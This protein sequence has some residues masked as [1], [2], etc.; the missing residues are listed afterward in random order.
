MIS[1]YN[2]L[3]RKL[4]EFKP[5]N[6]PNVGIYSCGPTVYW[7]QHIGHMYAYVQWDVLVRLLR[8]QNFK[9]KWA[10]NITDVGHLTSDADLGED[11]ME[12]GAKR[13][14]LTVWQI[15]DKYIEQFLQ[16]VDLLNIQRPDVLC[17]ATEH[18]QEQIDL[19][20]KIEARGF[21]YLTKTGL[22]FDT[23]KFPQYADFAK[24][25][26]EKQE[27]GARVKVDPEKKNPWDF[28]LWVTNQ[29]GHVMLW[30]SPWGK[31]FPGWHIECT[32][33][34]VKYL[35]ERFDIHTGGIEHISVHHTNEIAQGY[36]AFG[37][38]TANFWLHNGWLAMKGEKISKSLGN[39]ILVADLME[40]E[41]DPLAL[42]YLILN[43]H[44]RQGMNFTWE[45]LEAAQTAL[46]N[47]RSEIRNWDRPK[48]GCA[49]YEKRFMEAL[50]N[51]L[52]VSQGLAILWELVKSDQPTSAKAESL[53]KFDKILGLK[54][55]E[56]LGKPLEIP[57]EVQKLV[58][59]REKVRKVGDFKKADELRSRI[60]KTG[61]EVE[62]VPGGPKLKAK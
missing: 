32:A 20:K 5:I 44:Y 39:M 33:M 14:G 48:I 61:Y 59:E 1:F 24:L 13:E 26:L 43:S 21:T 53:L 28:L 2:T 62:D 3:T 19:I 30:D 58:D 38:Q 46:N 27:A 54:L 9:V 12:K 8:S 47:L 23:S 17:R 41:F 18:I 37:C 52:N 56:Y 49:E 7:N 15:A 4:E 34:S 25:N 6:P 22:V 45:A 36:G 60:E 42:R 51:D 31:G 11:K 35:G 50:N 10:M 40:K 57:K 16:S 29:P 55:D